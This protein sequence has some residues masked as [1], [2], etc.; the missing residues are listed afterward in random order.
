MCPIAREQPRHQNSQTKAYQQDCQ[1]VIDSM[2]QHGAA[3]P[4]CADSSQHY[5][6]PGG[7]D[8]CKAAPPALL[9]VV[10]QEP[11]E[12]QS[13]A[14]DTACALH[15]VRHGT[16]HLDSHTCTAAAARHS[17]TMPQT[18]I[19][20]WAPSKPACAHC[21]PFKYSWPT[22]EHRSILCQACPSATCHAVQPGE[23]RNHCSAPA[24]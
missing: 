16:Q 18:H 6:P 8:S 23:E 10:Q 4:P 5:F 2:Q 12:V 3:T 14:A 11:A 7:Y 13:S 1:F 9:H 20:S 21:V 17:C 24:M 22:S 15:T 19:F